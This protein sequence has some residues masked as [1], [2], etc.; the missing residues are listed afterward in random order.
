MYN[1]IVNPT[2]RRIININSLEGAQL[3]NNY[4]SH[5]MIGG[6]GPTMNAESG[7]D[8]V[9]RRLLALQRQDLRHPESGADENAQQLWDSLP[10]ENRN[11]EVY[12]VRDGE[13]PNG[14]YRLPINRMRNFVNLTDESKQKFRIIMFMLSNIMESS[15]MK[16]LISGLYVNK[17]NRNEIIYIVD[18]W[19][20]KHD[21]STE[22]DIQKFG[23]YDNR[24]TISTACGDMDV[25][26]QLIERGNYQELNSVMTSMEDE[27]NQ[28]E[29]INFIKGQHS[30]YDNS[31]LARLFP[32]FYG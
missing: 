26:N 16:G 5:F 19:A 14:Y 31:L 8:E 11:G 22:M 12:E 15:F 18:G 30:R 6:G 1:Y 32:P 9:Q 4:L 2:N 29:F 10:W 20:V 25:Y 24:Q 23:E 3:L 17:F 21:L 28:K 27:E 7:A 13:N